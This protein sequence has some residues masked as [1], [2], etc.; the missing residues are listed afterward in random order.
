MYDRTKNLVNVQG[1]RTTINAH[2]EPIC[3]KWV[4]ATQSC[5]K[6]KDYV[7]WGL[8]HIIQLKPQPMF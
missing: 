2:Y 7:M 6:T 4:H 8:V 5:A 3:E 1:D